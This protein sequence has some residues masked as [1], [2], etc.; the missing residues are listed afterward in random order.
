MG[1]L[2]EG[3]RA[4]KAAV[5]LPQDS[6]RATGSCTARAIRFQA[7]MPSRFS[8]SM[9]HCLQ[10]IPEGAASTGSVPL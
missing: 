2:C 8:G 5:A 3:Q 6:D 4:R 7:A 1:T 10:I 9:A